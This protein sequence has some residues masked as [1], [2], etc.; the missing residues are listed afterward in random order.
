M[1]SVSCVVL[2]AVEMLSVVVTV[3]VGVANQSVVIL[4]AVS[5]Q[6]VGASPRGQIKTCT[7]VL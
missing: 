5:V 7:K 4:V 6:L 1:T 3:G 2:M